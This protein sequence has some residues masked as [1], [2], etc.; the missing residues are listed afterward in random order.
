MNISHSGHAT[1]PE[2]PFPVKLGHIQ[3]TITWRPCANPSRSPTTTCAPAGYCLFAGDLWSDCCDSIAVTHGSGSLHYNI[4]E[5]SRERSHFNTT[6]ILEGVEG[7]SLCA[8]LLKNTTRDSKPAAGK[9]VFPFAVYSSTCWK[10]Y[11]TSSL[12][13]N[14]IQRSQC[15]FKRVFFFF[16]SFN[17]D[18]RV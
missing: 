15:A 6:G 10:Q 9:L 18:H 12:T 11:W 7:D 14:P 4:I 16:F 17:C 2:R 13:W 8:H 3:V 5:W 1:C